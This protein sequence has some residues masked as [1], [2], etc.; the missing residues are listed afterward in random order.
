M[1]VV[2]VA[3]PEHL[4]LL[5]SSGTR[6]EFVL[7]PLDPV[8]FRIRVGRVVH[9][10]EAEELLTFKDL[11][12]DPLT[13]QATLAGEPIDLTYMEYELLRFLVDNPVRVW[14]LAAFAD[15]ERY[16]VQ[17]R[18][19]PEVLGDVLDADH[20]APSFPV[21]VVRWYG[22]RPIRRVVAPMPSSPP[23]RTPSPARRDAVSGVRKAVPVSAGAIRGNTETAQRRR[24]P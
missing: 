7:T 23:L 3:A 2:V 12:L 9:H 18:G 16:P 22:P 20:A 13:Y 14:S 19:A 17:R 11:V 6:A 10:E 4:A 24:S 21:A 1:P 15:L 5:E 8:E